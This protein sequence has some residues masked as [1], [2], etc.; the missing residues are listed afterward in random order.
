MALLVYNNNIKFKKVVDNVRKYKLYVNLATIWCLL[1]LIS[2][3]IIHICTV[4]LAIQS[5]S[6]FL[7]GYISLFLPFLAEL[8]FFVY[9]CFDISSYFLY[10]VVVFIYFALFFVFILWFQ[11][12]FIPFESQCPKDV[13][14]RGTYFLDRVLSL[15]TGIVDFVIERA[16]MILIVGAITLAIILFIMAMINSPNIPV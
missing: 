10:N 14:Y 2:G 15:F 5:T 11:H 6:D 13:K 4:I 16:V 8:V 3:C 1:L 9:A 12:C 7:W